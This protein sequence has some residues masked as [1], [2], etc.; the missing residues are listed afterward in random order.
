[1]TEGI[2][3]RHRSG[4][5]AAE[6]GH[7][8]CSGGYEAS[9]Y[10]PRDGRKVRKTFARESE[11]K[12][13]RAD[14]K[15]ALDHGT[16]R[17]PSRRTLR[18]VS[19]AWLEGAER[20]QI[21][22]RS[23][24]A[25]K[26]STLRGYRCALEERVLPVI[27][28]RRLSSITTSDLQTLVDRWHFDGHAASTIRNWIK[29]LQ[30]IYRR[31][32]S[33]EGLPLNP[34][35]DLE[36]P[37]ANPTEV[38]IVAPGV[39]ARLLGAV[40]GEDRAIWGTALYAG[41]RYG[42]L[43][44]LRWDAVDLANGIIEVRESWDPREGPIDPKTRRSRRAVPLPSVLRKLLTS[45]RDRSAEPTGRML[46]FGEG[47]DAPFE[48][49]RLYRLADRAWHMAEIPGRLR[50]HQARHT[51][52]SFMI[53][54]GVN[55]K[56]LS[57]FMGHSSITVTFD[58][59]GHLMPGTEAEG[60]ALLDAYLTSRKKEDHRAARSE[61]VLP[62]MRERLTQ[63]VR[64]ACD[65]APCACKRRRFHSCPQ[66]TIRLAHMRNSTLDRTYVRMRKGT[67]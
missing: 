34:T 29:P 62:T 31:A 19:E 65:P 13:W 23:G 12:S 53:A 11:A 7:C 22:N 33:R 4:C 44:A 55:A 51:Y 10:S 27:G 42:E 32:R 43:R 14:A 20:G 41:L 18:E 52:A 2:R 15:R 49:E 67:Q 3:K 35:H 28:S 37:A 64:A 25:Y 39:A 45:Q 56:A 1:M 54:A 50:L 30:A 8:R 60:A 59:Y 9:V 26:P 38:E 66:G 17:A 48:A 5:P 57:T 21:R 16:L 58:L 61:N 6:G 47:E 46:V 40:P 24:N 63:A 36:L